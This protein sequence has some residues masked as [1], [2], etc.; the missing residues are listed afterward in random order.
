MYTYLCCSPEHDGDDWA[1]IQAYDAKEA[2]EKYGERLADRS[3]G[4][5]LI[6]EDDDVVRI[7]VRSQV[8]HESLWNVTVYYII[9]YRAKIVE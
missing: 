4:E 8:G 6:R 5:L 9:R 3:G 7:H 2:A 1:E